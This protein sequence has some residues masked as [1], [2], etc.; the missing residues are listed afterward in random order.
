MHSGMVARRTVGRAA[1]ASDFRRLALLAGVTVGGLG[2]LYWF[3]PAT[4]WIYPPCLIRTA[5][6][7]YCPGCGTTRALHA[8]LHGDLKQAAH[9]NLLLVAMLPA[10][11]AFLMVQAVS[12]ARDGR[13]RAIRAPRILPVLLLGVM[14][15]YALVR[16]LPFEWALLLAP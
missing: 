6:G 10:L 16:N 2:L 3:P 8:L 11:A 12:V 14:L 4:S 9:H 7:F 15:L 13:W 5:T 1:T